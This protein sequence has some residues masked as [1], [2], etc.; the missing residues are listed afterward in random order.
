MVFKLCRHKSD[1]MLF[2]SKSL[3]GILDESHDTVRHDIKMMDTT[4]FGQAM[5]AIDA[6]NF[7]FW[8][9]NFLFE[10]GEIR[11]TERGLWRF[12]WSIDHPIEPAKIEKLL[13]YI[14]AV[15]SKDYMESA[16][17]VYRKI[18]KVMVLMLDAIEEFNSIRKP[19]QLVCDDPMPG[20][21]EILKRLTPGLMA[22]SSLS[23]ADGRGL[24]G[25]G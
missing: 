8:A 5:E 7:D 23:E 14:N 3:A 12:L 2:D 21:L 1:K 15:K 10:D 16:M 17:G 19:D 18:Q 11:M 4:P 24:S 9:E 6:F 25:P 20:L 13:R 22:E